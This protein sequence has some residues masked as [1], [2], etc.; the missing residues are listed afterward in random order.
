MR[1]EVRALK[2]RPRVAHALVDAPAE[3]LVVATLQEGEEPLL[4]LHELRGG[5]GARQRNGML[6]DAQTV[7]APADA[8][9]SGLAGGSEEELSG[10]GGGTADGEAACHDEHPGQHRGRASTPARCPTDVL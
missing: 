9:L 8:R 1:A 7:L 5:D 2:E 6:L 3:L 10:V 4:V